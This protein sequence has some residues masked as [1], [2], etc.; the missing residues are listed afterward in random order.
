MDFTWAVYTHGEAGA[1]SAVPKATLL[2]SCIV[3][4]FVLSYTIHTL[5][6]QLAHSRTM[7][8]PSAADGKLKDLAISEPKKK[9]EPRPPKAAKVVQQPKKKV[10]IEDLATARTAIDG[11]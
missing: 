10:S 11:R 5:I 9:K 3:L 6:S 4:I 1:V 2:L 7:A 8:E